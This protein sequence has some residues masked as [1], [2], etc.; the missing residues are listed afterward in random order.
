VI[1]VQG[2]EQR[3]WQNLTRSKHVIINLYQF[4]AANPSE[5]DEVCDIIKAWIL[6]H[7]NNKTI[8]IGHFKYAPAGGRSGYFLPLSDTIRKADDSLLDFCQGNGGA[9][10]SS[11]HH[12]WSRRKQHVA[13]N[14]ITSNNHLSF[15]KVCAFVLRHK[16]YNHR[17]L[18]FTLPFED[19]ISTFKRPKRNF[20][21]SSDRVD[22][23]FFQ[24]NLLQW[25]SSI[26]QR[27]SLF[28]QNEVE[29]ET[30]KSLLDK[31]QKEQEIT[32]KEALQLQEKA[33]TS[34]RRSRERRSDRSK[35]QVRVHR[36][37]TTLA[38]AHEEAMTAIEH[39]TV[40]E[41]TI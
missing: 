40:T 39:A 1:R 34:R 36:L 6:K 24:K 21:I 11:R 10:V 19:F 29:A 27:I 12:A 15:P 25:H 5:Q 9:L 26:Q 32:R 22:V 31:M 8:L 3:F 37:H 30:G 17:V 41:A 2:C 18:S 13:H 4:T 28:M 7:S 16:N 35:E 23:V 20:N 33:E 38:V 14:A